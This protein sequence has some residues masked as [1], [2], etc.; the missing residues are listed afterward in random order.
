MA[1]KEKL[2]KLENGDRI[3]V[4]VDFHFDGFRYKY[5]KSNEHMGYRASVEL[6]EKGKRKGIRVN[7]ADWIPQ[8]QETALE[9]WQEFKP[10]FL[11]A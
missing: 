8:I 6:I 1:H 4:E 2:F 10:N 11:Q 7:N 9:L 3:R 5:D